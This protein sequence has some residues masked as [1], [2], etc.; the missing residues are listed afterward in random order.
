MPFQFSKQE[1]LKSR[2]IIGD[3]FDKGLSLKQSPLK[4]IYAKIDPPLEPKIQFAVA[5]PKKSF[6]GAVERNRIKRLIREA[7]RLNKG[8]FFNNIEG[9]YALLFLYLGKEMPTFD[10]IEKP[11]ISI[12]ENL[13]NR[14]NEK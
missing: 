5:V 7:Y 9:S 4:L 2:S 10:T 12:L 6:K 14:T 3:L 11:L 8:E 1:K 13:I